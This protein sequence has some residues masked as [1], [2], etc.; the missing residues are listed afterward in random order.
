MPADPIRETTPPDRLL[1][2]VVSV[3]AE[4][5]DEVE[6]LRALLLRARE[7]LPECYETLRLDIGAALE[8]RDAR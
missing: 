2:S 4:A 1:S 8:A 3:L 7:A 5:A 6:R